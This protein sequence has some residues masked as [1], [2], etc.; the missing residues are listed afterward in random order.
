VNDQSTRRDVL[1][2]TA[3]GLGAYVAVGCANNKKPLKPTA[4]NDKSTG[5]SFRI[6]HLTDFHVQPEDNAPKGFA[7]CLE[8]VQSQKHKPDLI[9]NTG[10]CVMN[11][12]HTDRA[13]AQAQWDVWNAGIRQNLSIPIKHG[14]GN[15]DIWGWAKAESKTTGSEPGWGKKWAMDELGLDRPYYAF[16]AGAWR[17]IMLDSCMPTDNGIWEARLDDEQFAWLKSE[18]EG[19]SRPILIGSHVP[20]ISACPLLDFGKTEGTDQY[21]ALAHRRSHMDVRK[22]G[23]MFARNPQVKLCI[24][25]H[26]HQIDRVEYRGVTYMTNPAVCGGWWTHNHMDI[27][28]P[29]FGAGYTM[30]DLHADGTFDAEHIDYGWRPAGRSATSPATS[31]TA[32]QPAMS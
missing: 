8:H 12:L 29:G 10:D 23:Q 25:G 21:P 17:V 31:P 19:T 9:F 22:L 11:V 13:R 18:I 20:I 30:L 15:H 32:T 1:K 6:A 27:V 5:G 16:D 7:M 3:L 2:S 4:L 14:I 28:P 26:L 24:S